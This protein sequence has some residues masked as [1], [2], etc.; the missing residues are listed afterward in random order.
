MLKNLV[1][2]FSNSERKKVDLEYIKLCLITLIIYLFID[3]NNIGSII[4]EKM[5][6]FLFIIVAILVVLFVIDSNIL[7]TIKINV[8]SYIDFCISTTLVSTIIYLILGNI[9]EFSLLKIVILIGIIGFLLILFCVRNKFISRVN[10]TISP[11]I[12][13]YDIKQLYDGKINDRDIIF[14]QEKDVDYDLLNRSGIINNLYDAITSCKNKESF[15]ISLVGAWGS[16]KTTIL[17][18]VKIQI[19]QN[20]SKEFIIIDNFDAWQYSNEKTLFYAMIDEIM[21]R[22]NINC[23]LL[24]MKKFMSTCLNMIS[25]NLDINLTPFNFEIDSVEKIKKLIHDYLEINDMRIIFI[26]DNLERTNE[27]NVLVVLKTIATILNLDRFIYILSYDENEM[28]NIFEK[29]LNINYAYLEKIIQLP[30]RIP[31]INKTDINNICSICVKNLFSLYGIKEIEFKEYED[32]IPLFCEKVRDMRDLKRKINSIFNNTFYC[33][34]Q[35]NLIDYFLLEIIKEENYNLYTNIR[36]NYKYYISEDQMYIKDYVLFDSKKYNKETKQYF[37]SLFSDEDNKSFEKIMRRL[38]PYVDKY[39]DS[40]YML[41]EHIEFRLE[42]P[43]FSESKKRDYSASVL[44]RRIFNAKFFDLYFVKQD[45]EFIYIDNQI[46]KFIDM[47]N[48]KEYVLEDFETIRSELINI[49]TIYKDA[50]QK[51][52]IE[53]L[54]LY[55]EKIQK[56]KLLF[57]ICLWALEGLLNDEMLFLQLNARDRVTSIC[58]SMLKMLDVD[59]INIVKELIGNGYKSMFFIGNVLHWLKPKENYV[60]SANESR[61]YENLLESYNKMLDSVEEKNINLYDSKTYSRRN[62]DCLMDSEKYKSQIKNIN[63]ETIFMFLSDMIS[64]SCGNTGYGYKIDLKK[65]EKIILKENVDKILKEINVNQINDKE[66]FILDVYNVSK[67]KSSD[68]DAGTLRTKIYVDL[69]NIY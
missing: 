28:R 4:Y 24:E 32:V 37:D 2:K 58:A 3:M 35:L 7:K 69:N 34:N 17:N 53:N 60:K 25:S 15:V 49:L 42:S 16:G 13:V 51:V 55:I 61:L 6:P 45:N 64:T 11:N 47:L 65:M 22:L 38:F 5:N 10:Y 41:R 19:T 29:R 21:K 40:I 30:M 67:Q 62:I 68:L 9:I 31:E 39:F 56:N 26:I 27:Q 43:Y 23:S 20:A 18:N 14:L 36:N 1:K 48:S 54:E 46:R 66:K 52:V 50:R 63:K 33:K 57:L 8:K 12:N 44:D 59:E